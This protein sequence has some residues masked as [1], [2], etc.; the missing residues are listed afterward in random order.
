MENLKDTSKN[1]NGQT[2]GQLT[3]SN[4]PVNVLKSVNDFD[5]INQEI[6]YSFLCKKTEKLAKALYLITSFLSD[7]E[8]LKWSI[9][10]SGLA[11]LSDVTTLGNAV[12][13]ETS[14]RIKKIMSDI[15]KTVSLL[16]ISATAGFVSEMNLA[17]LKE[18]YLSLLQTLGTKKKGGLQESFVFAR[19]FF[20]VRGIPRREVEENSKG[21]VKD[22]NESSFIRH[23]ELDSES[24]SVR[25]SSSSR[26]SVTLPR[27]STP[28]SESTLSVKSPMLINPSTPKKQEILSRKDTILQLIKAKGQGGE[29]SIKD[30]TSHFTDCGEKTIQRELSAL[31]ASNV[32]K[33][34]GD[35]RWS[36]YSLS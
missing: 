31:V 20:A 19:D 25:P 14:Q 10:E 22:T 12:V 5:E 28:E 1:S 8:P 23:S 18:E 21:Q 3:H 4:N 7:S 11:V 2:Q 26:P 30:I 16:E 15:E 24:T 36:K 29:L 9:R 13:T 6:S 32:L 33:K 27:L 35:R 34:S 17:I